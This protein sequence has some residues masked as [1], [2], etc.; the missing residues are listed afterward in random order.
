[1]SAG[2]TALPMIYDRW[3]KLYGRDYTTIIFPRLQR[4]L[5]R[6]R[7]PATVMLDVASGT[8]TLALRMARRGWR[9]WG[10][11]ASPFM[12]AEAMA[13]TGKYAG[14]VLFLHQDMRQIRLPE[15]VGLVT[16]MFDSLNHLAT[17]RDLLKTFRGVARALH[18]GGYFI[19]DLNNERCYRRLWTQTGTMEHR[20]FT[21]I[22]QSH[23]EPERRRASCLVTIFSRSGDRY[24][25]SGEVVE[26]RFYPREEVGR[27]L[28]EAGFRIVECGDFNF[29]EAPEVGNIKTWYVARKES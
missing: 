20:D 25:R 5:A 11:D 18:P 21:L 17:L 3:Q 28:A 4:S 15:R 23:Y 14:R 13:K 6:H 29:T 12:V 24:T 9:V 10:I 1:M 16:S 26:E 2:Y 22:L 7:I 8:G 19:F 27:L